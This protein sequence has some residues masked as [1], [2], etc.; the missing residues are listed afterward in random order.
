VD[1]HID[2]ANIELKVDII[3]DSLKLE[4]ITGKKSQNNVQ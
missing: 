2:G 1:K 3:V 4:E